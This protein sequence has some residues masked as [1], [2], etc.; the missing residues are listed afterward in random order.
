MGKMQK[1]FKPGQGYQGDW[2]DVQSPELTDEQIATAKPCQ[3]FWSRS[4]MPGPARN[5]APTKKLVSLRLSDVRGL[6]EGD[7]LAIG[8]TRICGGSARSSEFR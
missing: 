3:R 6:H 2:D 7:W 1:K 5:K 8:S 4:V